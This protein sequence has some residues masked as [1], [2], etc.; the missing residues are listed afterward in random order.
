[1]IQVG[2]F[3]IS[4][5]D[6]GLLVIDTETEE[7]AEFKGDSLLEAIENLWNAQF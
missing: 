5:T 4:L 1:M 6:G 7:G 2:K 3:S